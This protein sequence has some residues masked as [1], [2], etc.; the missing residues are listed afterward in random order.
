MTTKKPADVEYFSDDKPVKRIYTGIDELKDVIPVDN[1]RNRL[2]FCLN[3]YVNKEVS[4]VAEAIQ[5]A[6]PKSS[7][8]D[9]KKLEELVT[10]KL[11]EKGF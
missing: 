7:T 3:L 2:S 5:Q 6:Q 10:K 1:D 11:K 9:F 4:S 8:V